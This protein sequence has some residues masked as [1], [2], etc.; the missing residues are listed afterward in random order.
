MTGSLFLIASPID[1]ENVL[2]VKAKTMLLEACMDFEKNYILIEDIKPARR[3]WL[4]FGLPREAIEKMI[5]Y[6]EHSQVAL[7]PE[8]IANIKKGKNY[9]LMSD[10][11][12]PAFC[13]PGQ[14]LVRACHE[15]N[16]KVTSSPHAN[17]ISLAISLSG[18]DCAQFFFAGFLAKNNEDRIR[19][20]QELNKM[21]VPVILMDTPYRLKKLLEEISQTMVK[22][23]V[24][25]AMDLNQSTEELLFGSISHVTNKLTDNKREF[26]VVVE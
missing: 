25:L 10:G 8:I 21:N 22:R 14:K 15:N 19:H 16:I 24:F 6:N 26:I 20:L 2:D 13:D 11:G 12:L 4:H 17:S 9:Y 5:Q 1:E 7:I 3:R 18:I 23:K